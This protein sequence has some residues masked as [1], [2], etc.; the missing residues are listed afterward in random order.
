MVKKKTI[1]SR[2]Q[3][4]YISFVAAAIFFIDQITKHLIRK[5]LPVTNNGILDLTLTTNTG[6]L[7][8]LFDSLGG[9][10]LAFI[11]LSVIAILLLVLF[12]R[13]EDNTRYFFPLGLVIGGIL[14]NFV[15]RIFFQA[16]ID[17][18]RIP[19]WPIF[20]IADV[21][22]V[23]GVILLLFYSLREERETKKPSTKHTY[24]IIKKT[25]SKKKTKNSK[26]RK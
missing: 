11:V 15:D 13:K 22:L 9:S 17:W 24:K 18:I 21:A 5:H 6:S 19:R 14:G 10:N 1:H 20:N 12:F 23:L 3:W 7:F 8:G 16:V 26:A 25:R 2:K 4:L